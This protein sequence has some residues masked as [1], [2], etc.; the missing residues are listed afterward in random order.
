MQCRRG[1]GHDVEHQ[2]TVAEI[3]AARHVR[4]TA[5]DTVSGHCAWN[6]IGEAEALEEIQVTKG[7]MDA[8]ARPPDLIADLTNVIEAA[9]V[10]VPDATDEVV[11]G[12]IR[13]LLATSVGSAKAE[14]RHS[15]ERIE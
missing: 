3:G 2:R 8:H 4:P 12:D 13:G 10:G 5:R 7:G 1:T 14:D 6:Q 15:G 9:V 11:E